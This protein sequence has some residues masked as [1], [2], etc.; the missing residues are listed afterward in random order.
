VQTL[1]VTRVAVF[2]DTLAD[3]LMATGRI[4]VVATAQDSDAALV[5]AHR[6]RPDVALLDLPHPYGPATA[7]AIRASSP[8][9]QIVAFAVRAR[10]T[11]ILAWGKAGAVGCVSASES[12]SSLVIAIEHAANGQTTFS[13]ALAGTLFAAVARFDMSRAPEGD[14]LTRRERQILELVASEL[15]NQQIADLLH[16]QLPTVKNHVRSVYRKLQVHRREDARAWVV[17]RGG[18]GEYQAGTRFLKPA[19]PLR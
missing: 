5:A 9:T 14:S 17:S 18:G 16:L 6:R 8:G 13:E 2:R 12:L 10:D 19:G 7:S 4:S 3:A 11:E 1:L 15:S